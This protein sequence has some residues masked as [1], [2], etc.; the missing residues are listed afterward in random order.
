MPSSKSALLPGCLEP[1][2]FSGGKSH[3]D[4]FSFETS[5]KP[6]R[7]LAPIQLKFELGGVITTSRDI[8]SA[9][10][11][12]P[13][14]T[15][16]I[17]PASKMAVAQFFQAVADN[18]FVAQQASEHLLPPSQTV[19]ARIYLSLYGFLPGKRRKRGI[20]KHNANKHQAPFV[21]APSSTEQWLP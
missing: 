8:W 18:R 21:E 14:S 15:I 10:A 2:A 16:A 17:L 5:S 7:L 1:A 13:G 9:G 19:P 3:C 4:R 6:A 11:C 12:C 20:W